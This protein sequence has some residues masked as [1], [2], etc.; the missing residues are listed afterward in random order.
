MLQD[1]GQ[2]RILAPSGAATCHGSVTTS[3]E[4]GAARSQPAGTNL[5]RAYVLRLTAGR[6][7]SQHLRPSRS[8]K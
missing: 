1:D 5:I 3:L 7:H 6:H 2:G 4:V 8:F